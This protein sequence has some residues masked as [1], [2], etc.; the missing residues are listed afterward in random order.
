MPALAETRAVGA[1]GYT[2]AGNAET[3][4]SSGRL[5][6][7]HVL[8]R[9]GLGGT[10]QGLL[11]VIGEL[12][13]DEFEHKICAVRGVD[14]DFVSQSGLQVPVFSAGTPDPGFQFPLFRLARIMRRVRPHIVHSRNFG[15]LEAVLAAKLAR[16]PVV[17]HSE[18]GYELEILD[19]LPLRRRWLCR[20]LYGTADSVFT[21]TDELRAFHSRESWI[22]LERISVIHNG[23]NTELFASRPELTSRVR[24]DCG[25]PP[26]RLVIGSVGRMVPIKGHKTLLEAAEIAIGSGIDLHVLLVGAGSELQ[27]LRFQAQLSGRLRGRITFSGR[28]HRVPELLNGMDIFVLPSVREGMSNTVLEAMA[29]SLPVLLTNTGGN[30]ELVKDGV[31]GL[32]FAPGE[33]NSLA[34]C[35]G[36]MARDAGLR[37]EFGLAARRE[38]EQRF[39]LPEMIRK[40]REL[41]FSL[42][43]RQNAKERK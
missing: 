10:E 23:I 13:C 43:S 24:S 1:D 33:A 37:T 41:Y 34:E 4:M 8:P 16:V 11:K 28:S 30:L 38:V 7:L 17:I 20:A 6:I 39:S 26:G 21:V 31:H 27:N 2:W 22:P 29:T 40:Y 25:I 32:F 35:I 15:A 3:G 12:K 36:R 19:G 14:E 42:A 5:R 18:H 9:L